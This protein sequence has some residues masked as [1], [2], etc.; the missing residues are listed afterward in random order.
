MDKAIVVALLALAASGITA[1]FAWKSSTRATDVNARAADLEWV[2]AIKTDA[3]DARKEVEQL[4]VQLR[5]VSRQMEAVQREAEYWIA[6]YQVVHRTAWREGM[7]LARLRQFLGP[8]APPTPA[9]SA[10][11]N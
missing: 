1:F 3:S 4:Q 6:Q 7:T 10:N 9:A 8:D 11:G 5:Q 2:K